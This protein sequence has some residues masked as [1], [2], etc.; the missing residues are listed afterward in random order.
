MA[1]KQSVSFR[2]GQQLTMTPALQQAIRMLQL[3]ALD[4]QQEIQE[5]LDGNLMLEQV[6]DEAEATPDAGPSQ[7]E[8]TS[9]DSET[10]ADVD[11]N[12]EQ[13]V[14]ADWDD[15]DWQNEYDSG[16][17]GPAPDDDWLDYQNANRHEAPSLQ[18]H[19]AWQASLASLDPN[20]ASI[21]AHLIDAVNERGYLQDWDDLCPRLCD[22]YDCS[23]QDVEQVLEV[24]QEF[25]PP[26]VAARN[27]T[28]CLHLQLEQLPEQT[29]GRSAA[30]AI[31]DAGD[32]EA[33]AR[34][35]L[36]ALRRL[37]RQTAEETAEA[38]T[39]IQSLA[40]HPGD[41]F[42]RH[43]TQYIVPEV[44]VRKRQGRWTVSL[45]SALVPRVRVKPEYLAL[46]KRSE[47]S[48]DQTTMKQ[49]LQEARYLINSLRS[50]NETLLLVAQTIVETQRPFLEYGEEAMKPLV[51]RDI[52]EKLGMHESTISRATSNKYMHTPRGI[53][54]LKYFFSSSVQ[55]TTG[56]AASATAIQAM[57]KRLI[58]NEAENAPLSDSR[59]A[60]LLL[61]EGIRVARRTVAKYRE[62]MNIP[63][64]HE[65][66][67][68]ETAS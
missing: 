32:L 65:R 59:L 18:D 2:L 62:G 42:V 39:L 1:L 57:I 54:E 60:S 41:P 47:K 12:Q 66:R 8:P 23:P 55:T 64:S 24:L 48:A 15:S 36:A 44:F 53:Y 35:D 17:T 22:G 9:T 33:V 16:P 61:E 51:L 67:R 28:E 26:G 3:S 10:A 38:L 6:E 34:R 30:L 4:L 49:H 11:L 19:L 56:G 40:P 45:N 20:Q 63:P 29:V 31:V 25:D 13:P 21:I 14:E 37:C 50:R 43:E 68:S 7:E 46:V 52:A 5:A 27:I 58:S